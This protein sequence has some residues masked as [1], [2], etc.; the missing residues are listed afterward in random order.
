MGSLMQRSAGSWRLR[1]YAGVE[2]G[3]RVYVTRTVTGTEREARRALA[4]LEVEV[5][6]R[7]APRTKGT[8]GDLLEEWW[9][10]KAWKSAGG[11][12]QARSDIDRYLI[13]QL[14]AVK[15][16]R[17]DTARIDRLYAGLLDGSLAVRR[18][19]LGPGT[20][21]RLHVTL[22]AALT[23]GVRKGRLGSNPASVANAP[24]DPPTKI[25]APEGGEVWALIAGARTPEFAA[26]LRLAAATGRR[27][28]ELCALT[29]T[30]VKVDESAVVFDKRA[31]LISG[32]VIIEEM[33]KTGRATRV[34][35]DPET[36][37]TLVAHMAAMRDRAVAYGTVPARGAYLFSDALDCSSP[38]RPDSVSR[39]FRTLAAALGFGDLDLHGLRHA[40]V[41]ELLTAGVD[42]ETVA[43]RV[44]D[45]PRTIYKT[46]SHYRPAA[47][48]RAAGIWGGLLGPAPSEPEFST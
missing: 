10:V 7:R 12:R 30:D 34:H 17:L 37:A 38:W 39:R 41:T 32:G 3:Q 14:G 18:R 35:V 47:D 44:G 29:V 45:D 19:P 11:R 28:G 26:F 6:E 40:H 2:D 33:D 27:R 1:V 31:V 48:R 22:H 9:A 42:V 20:V 21:R 36:M 43:Q 24:V 13:P 25:R 15:L 4:R 16:A 23:W 8:V 46:Y 5:D